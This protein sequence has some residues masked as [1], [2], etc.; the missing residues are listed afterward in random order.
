[1][2]A[3]YLGIMCILTFGKANQASLNCLNYNWVEKLPL[4]NPWKKEIETVVEEK[5]I[6]FLKL[7][8]K[9]KNGETPNH[10]T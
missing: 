3:L 1:M 4:G 7:E 9:H 10:A 2:D 6:F 8:Q 5:R